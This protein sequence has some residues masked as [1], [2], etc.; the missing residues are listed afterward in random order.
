M[1][2]VSIS[3]GLEMSKKLGN[4]DG[5]FI[6]TLSSGA[7]ILI[8][9][10]TYFLILGELTYYWLDN[11]GNYYSEAAVEELCR[12]NKFEIINPGHRVFN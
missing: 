4:G 11:K 12:T 5:Q 7:S 10:T 3:M 2:S 9:H 6:Y 8:G 1:L